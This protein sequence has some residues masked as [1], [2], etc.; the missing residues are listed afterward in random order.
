ML[1][2]IFVKHTAQE[3]GGELCK[4]VKFRSFQQLKY[5]NCFSFWRTPYRGFAPWSHWVTFVPQTPGL[6]PPPQVRIPGAT[7]ASFC[8]ST[9]SVYTSPWK[10][11]CRICLRA[12][13]QSQQDPSHSLYRTTY[14]CQQTEKNNAV[15]YTTYMYLQN[16]KTFDDNEHA[17]RINI[18]AINDALLYL[19]PPD[20]MPLPTWNHFWGSGR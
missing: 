15:P 3:S 16:K 7:R 18:N 17:K 6:W 1:V 8:S 14:C 19:R 4:T 5:L 13:H 20:A 11:C 9:L 2:I 10:S 12:N